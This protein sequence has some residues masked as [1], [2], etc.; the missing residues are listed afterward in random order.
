MQIY[1]KRLFSFMLCILVTMSLHISTYAA[2]L[3]Y[4]YSDEDSI[5]KWGYSPSVWYSKLDPDGSFAFFSGLTNG[6]DEWNSALGLRVS[7]SSA[8]TSAP[9]KFYGGTRAQLN[10]LNLTNPISSA[11]LGLT[12]YNDTT[13]YGTH[14]YNGSTKS[15]YTYNRLTGF[16]V[17]RSDMDYN[18]YLKTATHEMGH[19]LG[20][21]GHPATDQPTWVMEQGIS[22]VTSLSTNEKRHLSQIY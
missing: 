20:W 13:Y 14:T 21:D 16:V 3:R 15:W 5:G 11:Y 6:A 1:Q 18:N 9:I 8:N 17:S 7:V 22:S 10:A 19:I 4:W 2:T 12:I